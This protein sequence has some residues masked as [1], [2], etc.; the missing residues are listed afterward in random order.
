MFVIYAL[1]IGLL[2]GLVLGGRLA[3]LADLKFRWAALAVAGFMAQV[4]LFSEPVSQRIGAFG[5]P[6]YV[7]STTLV[8]LAVFANIR[9]RGMALVAIGAASNLAAIVA[10]GGY[11][12]A[13]AAAAAAIGRDPIV[14]YSNSAIIP[15]PALEPLTDVIALPTWLP[16]TNI[17]SIG[18]LFIGLGIVVVI[19]AAMRS[20]RDGAVAAANPVAD[21]G[22]PAGPAL[23]AEPA[24]P[25]DTA[26][27]PVLDGNSPI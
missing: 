24:G 19:V 17:V 25:A 20:A 26:S 15:S 4:I 9:I 3:G 10:N 5:P 6:I 2:L 23:A 16:F 8:L 11:M 7:A 1:P 22:E 21:A 18:D 27:A 13:S 14:D 12:P